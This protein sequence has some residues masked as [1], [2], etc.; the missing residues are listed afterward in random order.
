MPDA[1]TFSGQPN[2]ACDVSTSYE[3]SVQAG[4]QLHF[5]KPLSSVENVPKM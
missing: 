2:F 1:F 3:I 5:N 4:M